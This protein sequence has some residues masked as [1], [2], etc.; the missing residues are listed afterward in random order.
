MSHPDVGEERERC[1]ILN[2]TSSHMHPPGSHWLTQSS[3]VIPDRSLM[4][5]PLFQV[6]W[7]LHVHHAMNFL[8]SFHAMLE[9]LGIILLLPCSARALE[10]WQSYLWEDFPLCNTQH[11]ISG[12]HTALIPWGRLPQWDHN[13][14][15]IEHGLQLGPTN[16]STVLTS[17][18][19]PLPL[20][21]ARE[22]FSNLKQK[23]CGL[24]WCVSHTFCLCQF[25]SFPSGFGLLETKA[26]KTFFAL[27]PSPI[28]ELER[29][30]SGTINIVGPSSLHVAR[31]GRRE[32]KHGQHF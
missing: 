27:S 3:E 21:H 22:T 1:V 12:T 15:N 17:P 8:C 6:A 11:L 18:P 16:A 28:L 13:L 20:Y 10:L 32:K 26:L 19:S 7:P 29:P 23:F 4:R 25:S 14:G 9:S 30:S 5:C 24:L 31:A 2:I